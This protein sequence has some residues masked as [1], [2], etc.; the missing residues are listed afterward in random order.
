MI[1]MDD[2]VNDCVS[3]SLS[4]YLIKTEW[5]HDK[6]ERV[7]LEAQLGHISLQYPYMISRMQCVVGPKMS[8]TAGRNGILTYVPRNLPDEEKQKIMLLLPILND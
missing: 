3:E 6:P 8:F 5:T 1:K 2:Y 4:E 7:S